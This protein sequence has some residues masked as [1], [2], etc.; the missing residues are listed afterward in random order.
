ML[1]EL[2]TVLSENTGAGVGGE[3]TVKPKE[4][5][6]VPTTPLVEKVPVAV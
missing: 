5:D 3:G 4:R 6:A 1:A 2:A